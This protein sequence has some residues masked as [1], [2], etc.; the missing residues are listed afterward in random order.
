MRCSYRISLW[1]FYITLA[2]AGTTLISYNATLNRT[3]LFGSHVQKSTFVLTVLWEMFVVCDDECESVN[4]ALLRKRSKGYT[5]CQISDLRKY[6][7]PSF[8]KEHVYSILAI[9]EKRR[10]KRCNPKPMLRHSSYMNMGREHAVRQTCTTQLHKCARCIYDLRFTHFLCTYKTST[11]VYTSLSNSIKFLATDFKPLIFK[12][13]TNP[14]LRTSSA[15]HILI[16]ITFS[17]ILSIKQTQK[18]SWDS[19]LPVSLLMNTHKY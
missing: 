10:K 14:L 15:F 11:W 8:M 13:V 6:C 3:E 16:A 9:K 5:L 19:V 18:C 7:M 17:C 2:N 4:I 1:A 12:V